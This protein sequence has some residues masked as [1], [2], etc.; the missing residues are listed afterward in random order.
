MR[1]PSRQAV[2]LVAAGAD[3]GFASAAASRRVL[4]IFVY[5]IATDDRLTFVAAPLALVA[6]YVLQSGKA[7]FG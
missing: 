1:W 4:D 7:V 5:A 6:C 3:I 2:A